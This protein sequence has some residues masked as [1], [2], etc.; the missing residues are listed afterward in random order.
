MGIP[1]FHLYILYWSKVVC[2]SFFLVLPPF[3][4]RHHLSSVTYIHRFVFLLQ[5]INTL[6]NVLNHHLIPSM[7]YQGCLY[8][9]YFCLFVCIPWRNIQRILY[10]CWNLGLDF[11]T[12]LYLSIAS[13]WCYLFVEN[14]SWNVLCMPQVIFSWAWYN[15]LMVHSLWCRALISW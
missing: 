9:S 11:S 2:S 12:V 14:K 1:G 5:F 7:I 6:I 8:N 15:F 4:Q 10:S 13:F 3:S